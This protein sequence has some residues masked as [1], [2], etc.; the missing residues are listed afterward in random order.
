MSAIVEKRPVGRPKG[1]TMGIM[2]RL[3]RYRIA[4]RCAQVTP[5]IVDFWKSVALNKKLPIAVRMM[6]ADRLMERAFGKA[7]VAVQVDQTSCATSLKKAERIVRWL[8]SD[9]RY[10][11]KL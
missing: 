8:R 6:A 7:A 1:S 2:E 9:R 11:S 10:H 3:E 4:E 5:Q